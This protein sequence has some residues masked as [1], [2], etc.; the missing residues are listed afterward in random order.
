MSDLAGK[1]AVVTGGTRGIG[2]A[3]ALELAAAGARVVACHREPG[4][5]DALAKELAD[6]GTDHAVVCADVTD[7]DGRAAIAEAART[8]LGGVDVLVNNAGVHGHGGVGELDLAEWRRVLEVNTAAPFTVTQAL[9]PQL[10]DGASVVNIGASAALRGRPTGAHY[11]AS[12]AAVAG[13]TRSL[14]KELGG[15]GIRVNLVAPGVVDTGDEPLPPP[16]LA[17]I[18]AM[19]ALRRLGSPE[20][21]A[22]A[23]AFLAGD[24]SR[25]ITGATIH[26]DG[27]M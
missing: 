27:G 23:V 8:H 2:R 1:R 4:S 21:V 14:A 22:R 12:K 24:G 25:Y 16:A 6:L 7:P 10:A 9:L 11:G 13:L 5:G 3:V 20:D 26:V 17:R 19:T 18:T 15:R